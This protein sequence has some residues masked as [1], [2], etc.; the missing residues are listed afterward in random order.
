MRKWT[1]WL[2]WGSGLYAGLVVV[3]A[4]VFPPRSATQD[5]GQREAIP[6]AGPTHEP[7][8]IRV[9]VHGGTDFVVP[10]T[11]VITADAWGQTW[12][13]TEPVAILVCIEQ[14]GELGKFVVVGGDAFAATGARNLP[15][16]TM[17]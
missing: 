7:S 12:P 10:K 4:V 11:Q 17:I 16:G 6:R 9:R 3:G 5:G 2:L 15:Q 14:M 8:T 13:F 1:R